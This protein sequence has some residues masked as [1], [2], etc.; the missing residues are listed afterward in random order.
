MLLLKTIDMTADKAKYDECAK[1]LLT[2]DAV[3]AW[4]LKSCTKEFSQYSVQFIIDNCLL[5]RPEISK[6]A[7]HQD[8]LDKCQVDGTE[9]L[10]GD[11]RIDV[12]NTESAAI[13]EQTVYFDIRFKAQIPG[14][15]EQYNSSSIW[16]F[17]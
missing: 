14:E 3:I 1:K 13:K 5:G 4:I 8:Q 16:K 15:K 10:D 12:M 11:R 6:K 9:N 2:Y 17:K 7:V